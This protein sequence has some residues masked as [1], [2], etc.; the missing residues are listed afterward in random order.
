L[1]LTEELKQ[2]EHERDKD[3]AGIGA[4]EPLK[5]LGEYDLMCPSSKRAIKEAAD[6]GLIVVFPKDNELQLDIDNDEAFALYDSVRDIIHHH[7]TVKNE[8]IHT[9]RSGGEKRHITITL[10]RNIDNMERI[11]L[12]ACLG[13]DRKRE[14]L[15]IIQ[16]INNDEHPSLF[17]EVPGAPNTPRLLTEGNP[18][19]AE[20]ES[21]ICGDDDATRGLGQ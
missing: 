9:S 18:N 19:E 21:P 14:L 6:S 16:E 12:Q 13:S 4:L 11:A 8:E 20:N 5:D 3:R 15:S 7:Y 2:F 17:L 10:G 1:D